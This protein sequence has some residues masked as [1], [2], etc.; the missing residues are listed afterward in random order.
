[1]E[2][3]Q[4]GKPKTAAIETIYTTAVKVDGEWMQFATRHHRK[5]EPPKSAKIVETWLRAGKLSKEDMK[6]AAAEVEK[7]IA[8]ML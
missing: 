6:I 3:L 2:K 5:I 1:M 8:E 4:I 7:K